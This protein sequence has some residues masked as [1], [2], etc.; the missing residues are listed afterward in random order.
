MGKLA[1]LISLLTSVGPQPGI[2]LLL[3]GLHRVLHK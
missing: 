2:E 1:N 3:Q